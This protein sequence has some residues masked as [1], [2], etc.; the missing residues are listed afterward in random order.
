MVLAQAET[1]GRVVD[2][3]TKSAT[4]Y[5]LI[6]ILL[7]LLLVAIGVFV[8]SAFRFLAPLFRDFVSSTVELHT[9]LKET[10]QRQ[11]DLLD[12]HKGKLSAIRLAIET[13]KC[14]Y[15]PPAST[16]NAQGVPVPPITTTIP[17]G[18]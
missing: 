7:L 10:T 4:D 1:V 15:F 14:P 3:A 9:S 5:G 12:D 17:F 18:V 6:G 2:A 8:W 16:T 11:T 13:N